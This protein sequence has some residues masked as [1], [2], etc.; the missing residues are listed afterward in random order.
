MHADL[1]QRVRVS[2]AGQQHLPAHH[3]LLGV[4]DNARGDLQACADRRDR[5]PQFAHY[6]R[7]SPDLRAPPSDGP[8][9]R[10]LCEGRRSAQ[11]CRGATPIPA[12]RQHLDPVP[13]LRLAHGHTAHDHCLGGAAQ[14][15][16][17]GV[18]GNGQSA[19]ADQLFDNVLHLLPVQRGLSQHADAHHQV[20]VAEGQAVPPGG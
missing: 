5:W 17:S 10:H 6:A 13:A 16:V 11:V 20:A 19:G 12:A 18:P 15:S 14:L 1:E 8:V 2:P 9:A 7:L 4:Q 3:L